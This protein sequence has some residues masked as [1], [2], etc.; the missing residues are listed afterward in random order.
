[1]I[2]DNVKKSLEQIREEERRIQ[3]EKYSKLE[4]DYENLSVENTN[5][6]KE[7]EQMKKAK[8]TEIVKLLTDVR[9]TWSKMGKLFAEMDGWTKKMELYLP[10]SVSQL[11]WTTVDLFEYAVQSKSIICKV[12]AFMKDRRMQ[13]EYLQ[14]ETAPASV[15]ERKLID[16]THKKDLLQL[17]LDCK[18]DARKLSN[19]MAKARN[20]WAFYEKEFGLFC[21]FLFVQQSIFLPMHFK[22]SF[23][24]TRTIPSHASIDDD[25]EI[26]EETE[27]EEIVEGID[28]EIEKEDEVGAGFD[29]K[30]PSGMINCFFFQSTRHSDFML[31][32]SIEKAI[33]EWIKGSALSDSQKSQLS[34]FVSDRKDTLNDLIPGAKD[35]LSLR[36]VLSFL[37]D[38]E[39]LSREFVTLFSNILFTESGVCFLFQKLN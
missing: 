23:L 8:T 36:R 9:S 31:D 12:W 13:F 24:E 37:R 1:M 26:V 11:H 32:F 10:M 7:L 6:K 17:Y 16:P 2:A 35:C 18:V 27:K 5:I 30:N 4:R 28:E 22:A 20:K 15:K 38:K 29:P 21:F 19:H 25:E 34:K 33:L 3:Q 14:P 39:E